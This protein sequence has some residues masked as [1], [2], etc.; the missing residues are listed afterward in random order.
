MLPSSFQPN[1]GKRYWTCGRNWWTNGG[2][3]NSSGSSISR[4]KITRQAYD[5]Y[6]T[7]RFKVVISL[8]ACYDDFT[9]SNIVYS[10]LARYSDWLRYSRL[11]T[12][13]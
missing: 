2:R 6:D 4:N 3:L 11:K 1:T 5:N 7:I 8:A 12:S 13:H 10:V 9:G